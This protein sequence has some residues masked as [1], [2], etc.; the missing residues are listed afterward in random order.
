M[1]RRLMKNPSSPG[2]PPTRATTPDAKGDRPRA[3][4]FSTKSAMGTGWG[5]HERHFHLDVNYAAGGAG[6]SDFFLPDGSS[7]H[8]GR[9]KN[10]PTPHGSSTGDRP[11]ACY[12]PGQLAETW[13]PAPPG[14]R[15]SPP[16]CR[17]ANW[18][19]GRPCL[20]S[21]HA[22]CAPQL[23]TTTYPGAGVLRCVQHRR[24]VTNHGAS[25]VF[26]TRTRWCG[27][28]RE[29]PAGLNGPS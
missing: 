15:S 29:N 12:T 14:G 5:W 18:S 26:A 22:A 11:G 23:M 10:G 7:G 8:Q 24:E 25:D 2:G 9:R 16:S 6:R 28:I 19:A 21:K 17:A 13:A 27:V 20:T 4:T 3:P 1:A